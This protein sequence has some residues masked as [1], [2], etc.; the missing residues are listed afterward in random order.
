MSSF[1]GFVR[2]CEDEQ[3]LLRERLKPLESGRA[4]YGKTPSGGGPRVDLVPGEVTRLKKAIVELD[5]LIE[6]YSH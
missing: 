2:W 3:K 6:R 1:E 5:E 4:Q